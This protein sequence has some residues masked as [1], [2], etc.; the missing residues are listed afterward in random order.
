MT[1]CCSNIFLNQFTQTPPDVI[2]DPPG[3]SLCYHYEDVPLAASTF[4]LQT[5]IIDHV[6][7]DGVQTI[8][9]KSVVVAA[10]PGDW[11]YDYNTFNYAQVTADLSLTATAAGV[12]GMG[13]FIGVDGVVGS[14]GMRFSVTADGVTDCSVT[15][16]VDLGL[17]PV[18]TTTPLAQSNCDVAYGCYE[19]TYTPEAPFVI[20]YGNVFAVSNVGL[21]LFET[22]YAGPVCTEFE[23]G[24]VWVTAFQS[25]V[26][27]LHGTQASTTLDIAGNTATIR[28]LNTLL[29]P[30]H[31]DNHADSG[32][33]PPNSVDSINNF[34]PI[35]CP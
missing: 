33:M 18:Q 32:C 11:G 31:M 3:A 20:D 23:E 4:D 5:L 8:I 13:F 26:Q 19:A 15:Y 25:Y 30:L 21:T 14:V 34:S 16:T 2:V 27:T 9:N 1:R 22:L 35:D 10:A 24:V 29:V 7:V 28:I 6:T 12:L 17:G